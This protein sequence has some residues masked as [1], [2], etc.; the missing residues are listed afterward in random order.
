MF[1]SE[2]VSVVALG[3]ELEVCDAPGFELEVCDADGA[4]GSL[5]VF[6]ELVC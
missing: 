1:W 4:W 6:P 5:L 2:V 3:F